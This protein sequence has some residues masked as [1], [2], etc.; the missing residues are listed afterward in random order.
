MPAQNGLRL[1]NSD[2]ATPRRQQARADEQLQPVHEVELRA[3]A[4]A[5]KNVDLMAENGVLDDQLPPGSDGI[6]GDSSDLVRRTT[7]GQ[8]RPQPSYATKD[9]PPDSRD[10]RRMH[11][12]LEHNEVASGAACAPRLPSC[13]R[14][15]AQGR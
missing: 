6:Q 15:D 2:R 11:A 1:D 13:S 5:S 12:Q 3:L 9:L 10:T 8:L 7:R 4:A 14:P